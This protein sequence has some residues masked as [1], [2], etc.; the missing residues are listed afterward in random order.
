MITTI[1]AL[2]DSPFVLFL[3]GIAI[4]APLVAWWYRA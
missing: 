3:L 2:L 4:A 1:T